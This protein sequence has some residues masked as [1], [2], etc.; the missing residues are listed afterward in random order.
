MDKKIGL[1]KDAGWQFG[2]RRTV[3]VNTEEVWNCLFS[4]K[5]ASIWL[6]DADLMFSTNKPYSHIRTKWN[7][8]NWPNSANLQMRVIPRKT[9]TTIAFHIDKLNNEQQRN[10][11]KLYWT[12]V[13]TKL[14]TLL[15]EDKP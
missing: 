5:Y 13:L 1:T 2:I 3:P 7:L 4:K 9:K 14:V 15:K 12:S 8:N 11:S 6:K 10:E